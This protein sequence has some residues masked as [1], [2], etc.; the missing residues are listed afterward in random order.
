MGA[1]ATSILI[2]LRYRPWMHSSADLGKLPSLILTCVLVAS[3]CTVRDPLY[4]DESK[5]CTSPERPYCDLEGAYE[6][7]GYIRNTCI[8]TP[9]FDAGGLVDAPALPGTLSSLT[10]TAAGAAL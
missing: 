7:S 1:V 8:A 5:P 3:A 10:V 6:E 4:C 2:V 9:A